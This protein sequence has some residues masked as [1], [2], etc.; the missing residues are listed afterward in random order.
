MA[1]GYTDGGHVRLA[2]TQQPERRGPAVQ[3]A[4]EHLADLDEAGGTE[5]AGRAKEPV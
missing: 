1:G 5:K 3:C 4:G 2:G